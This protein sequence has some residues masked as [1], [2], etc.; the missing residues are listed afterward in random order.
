MSPSSKSCRSRRSD[1]DEEEEEEPSP[2]FAAAL[3]DDL[4]PDSLLSAFFLASDG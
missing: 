2:L 3:P 1:D 4:S